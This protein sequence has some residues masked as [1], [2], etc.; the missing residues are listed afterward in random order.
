MRKAINYMLPVLLLVLGYLVYMQWFSPSK[1]LLFVIPEKTTFPSNLSSLPI[2]SLD[3]KKGSLD[4]SSHSYTIFAVESSSNVSLA[5]YNTLKPFHEWLTKQGIQIAY[6]WSGAK[7]VEKTDIVQA[8]DADPFATHVDFDR[9]L[10]AQYQQLGLQFVSY[11]LVFVYSQE[12]EVIY[13]QHPI[14]PDTISDLMSLFR[15]KGNEHG[16]S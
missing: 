2:K 7:N 12:G 5:F 14:L 10:L 4:I 16:R 1:P 8:V 3:G 13:F 9:R 6:L 15:D 11:P